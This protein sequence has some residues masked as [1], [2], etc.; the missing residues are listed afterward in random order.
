MPSK[1]GLKMKIAPSILSANFLN[2][3]DEIRRVCEGGADLLHID[4]MD[5]HF[6]PNLT[7]GSMIVEQI[8]SISTIP[9]DVHLMVENVPFFIQSLLPLK[10]KYVSFHIEEEKHIHRC[11]ELLRSHEISPALTLNPHTSLEGLKY[12]LPSLD[13]VLLMSVNPGFGGQKFIPFT[14]QK[15]R[16]LKEMI[17]VYAPNCLIEVDGGVSNENAK[18]LKEA[19]ADIL[20]AGS[21]VFKSDDYTKAIQSL[22]E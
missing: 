7:F 17:N 1:K 12:I 6:V 9:L 21:Y 2:L 4:I 3:G 14:L 15:I 22:K 5:G 18:A 13:M 11:V 20:V 10:P 19:G 8:A 16:D